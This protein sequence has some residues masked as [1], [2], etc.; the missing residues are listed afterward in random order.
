MFTVTIGDLLLDRLGEFSRAT[1]VLKNRTTLQAW[2]AAHNDLVSISPPT[3]GT[4]VLL[5][6]KGDRSE[7]DSFDA[8]ISSGVL[9]APG[10]CF[11]LPERPA[12]FRL[13][14]GGSAGGL[15]EGLARV[16]SA[17]SN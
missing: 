7:V 6:L 15:Q 13:G 14:Y 4:T 10:R 11:D 2:A 12:R 17:I 5:E 9:L 16:I 1:H 8:L 3:G